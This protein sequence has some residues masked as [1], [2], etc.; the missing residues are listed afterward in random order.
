LARGESIWGYKSFPFPC[1]GKKWVRRFSRWTNRQR[2][3]ARINTSGIKSTPTKQNLGVRTKV[4]HPA[5]PQYSEENGYGG[6]KKVS[7]GLRKWIKDII[8]EPGS[9]SEPGKQQLKHDRDWMCESNRKR[10]RITDNDH[11]MWEK[12]R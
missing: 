3:L 2:S 1:G 6:Y 9:A 12:Q 5:R 8:P 7:I 10:R 4:R 11:G